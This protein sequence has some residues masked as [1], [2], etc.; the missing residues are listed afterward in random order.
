MN[1]VI[2]RQT[3]ILL[4]ESR[5]VEATPENSVVANN[6]SSTVVT[7]M[8][9]QV[10][11]KKLGRLEM[12][13]TRTLIMGVTSLCVMP[14]LNIVLI[15]AFFLLSTRFWTTGMLQLKRNAVAVCQRHVLDSRY[16]RSHNFPCEKQRAKSGMG[17]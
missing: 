17:M 14:F 16:L 12:E 8:F 10:G 1:I 2:Y 11:R 15:G 7:P 3:K 6:P 13:A 4:R 5:I 9:I